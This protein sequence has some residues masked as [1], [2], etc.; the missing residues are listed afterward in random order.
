MH[1]FPEYTSLNYYT[2]DAILV[3]IS[4]PAGTASLIGLRGGDNHQC[5]DA[6]GKAS[7][8]VKQCT[9]EAGRLA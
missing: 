7:A 6:V 4:N 2:L 9:A 3:S 8:L 5:V 1:Q